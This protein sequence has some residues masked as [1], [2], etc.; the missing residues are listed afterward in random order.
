M[1][2]TERE[3]PISRANNLHRN[4]EVS[5]RRYRR[6]A[7]GKN[8]RQGA[9]FCLSVFDPSQRHVSGRVALFAQLCSRWSQLSAARPAGSGTCAMVT[10]CR[11]CMAEKRVGLRPDIRATEL[12][13]ASWSA[14]GNRWPVRNANRGR[15]SDVVPRLDCWHGVVTRCPRWVLAVSKRFAGQVGISGGW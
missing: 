1:F 9:R 4:H 8:A 14:A 2:P 7:V 12:Y 11:F 13:S 10:E 5:V 3:A 15:P 6:L